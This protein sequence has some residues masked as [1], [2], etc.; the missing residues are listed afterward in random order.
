[1][2]PTGHLDSIDAPYRELVTADG[3]KYVCFPDRSWMMFN[4]NKDPLEES[5]MAQNNR[6]KAERKKLIG[7]LRQ[8]VADTGDKFAVPEDLGCRLWR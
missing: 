4:L 7:R 5:N 1:M 6:Y 3:W 2:I 8:W